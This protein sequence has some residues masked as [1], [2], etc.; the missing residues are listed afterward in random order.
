MLDWGGTTELGWVA[1]SRVFLRTYADLGLT[2][3]QAM[4][5]IHVL[6]RQWGEQAPFPKVDTLAREM[7]RSEK[8]V[9]NGLRVLRDKGLLSTVFRKGRY[10][11]Y[12]FSPLFSKLASAARASP[13]DTGQ[14]TPTLPGQP[15]PG[16]PGSIT[17]RE[18][19]QTEKKSAPP[20]GGVSE[21][22]ER[23][24]SRTGSSRKK[25]RAMEPVEPAQV[26]RPSPPSETK[27]R[28]PK[29]VACWNCNDMERVFRS[30][31][32]KRWPNTPPKRWTGRER[33]NAKDFIIEYEATTVLAVVEMVLSK[34]KEL[35]R[36]FDW[37]G[38]PSMPLMYGYR[39]SLVPMAL[40]GESEPGNPKWGAHWDEEAER[41]DGEEGGWGEE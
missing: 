39:G 16:I 2:P 1:V 33:K 20:A 13:R 4:L 14:P 37:K 12:D 9:R 23:A 21:A 17:T 35:Q 8:S 6:D 34:W 26:K 27:A 38:Y 30:L 29:S 5:T 24:A 36:Q 19:K 3:E 28:E 18:E 41:P 32:S 7:G 15:P 22:L 40:E 25:R 11:E 10:N 31:W